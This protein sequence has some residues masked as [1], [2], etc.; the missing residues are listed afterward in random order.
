[1][2]ADT[3]EVLD[4]DTGNDVPASVNGVKAE[5]L[6]RIIDRIERLER[7]KQ[8]RADDIALVKKEAKA[9]GF[10]VK[11]INEIIKLRKQDLSTIREHELLVS[12]YKRAL[13][14]PE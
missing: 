9:D 11:V 2:S 6:Q 3:A 13:G 5:E 1:M 14:M 7:E 12:V 4:L 8:E 10:N